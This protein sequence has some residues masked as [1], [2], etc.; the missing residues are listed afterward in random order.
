MPSAAWQ[1]KLNATRPNYLAKLVITGGTPCHACT[2]VRSSHSMLV[3]SAS[4]HVT[5]CDCPQYDPLCGCGHVLSMHQWGTSD[6]PWACA[7]CPCKH[8]G[9]RQEVCD[10]LTLFPIDAAGG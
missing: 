9:G 5:G 2:H 8:F 7:W 4:C 10:P 1:R 3:L 6:A